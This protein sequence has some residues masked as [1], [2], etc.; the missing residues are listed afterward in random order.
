MNYNLHCVALLISESLYELLMEV[1]SSSNVGDSCSQQEANSLTALT[2]SCLLSL[3]IATGNTGKILSACAATLMSPSQ[4]ASQ[5]IKVGLLLDFSFSG[6]YVTENWSYTLVLGV[7]CSLRN[8]V[9]IYFILI[10]VPG[11][12]VALQKSVQAV[13]LGKTLI[14]EWLTQGV[15]EKALSHMIFAHKLNKCKFA[16]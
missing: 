1:A 15:K 3:V 11:I 2:C 6:I 8:D 4:M 13:L 10:Q 12:L 5:S 16:K 9:D 7:L 14:P